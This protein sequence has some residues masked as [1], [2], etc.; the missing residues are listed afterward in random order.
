VVEGGVVL[1]HARWQ[2]LVLGG[3]VAGGGGACHEWS[4]KA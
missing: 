3:G 4:D 1:M 2:Q